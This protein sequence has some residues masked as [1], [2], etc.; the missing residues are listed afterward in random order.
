M[1]NGLIAQI[2][3]VIN[4]PIDLL[5]GALNIINKIPNVHIPNIQR[6]SLPRL[7]K[8]GVL[9]TATPVIAGEYLGAKANPEIVTPQKIMA[10][11]FTKVLKETNAQPSQQ[12]TINVSGVFATSPD[13]RRKVAD[14]IMQAFEQSQKARFA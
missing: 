7:A 13:E 6:F 11:T 8:G 4:K 5:N 10:D 14:Q 3:R 2:E 12:I 1:I 9:T